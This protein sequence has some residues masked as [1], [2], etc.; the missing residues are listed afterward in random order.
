MGAG[1]IWRIVFTLLIFSIGVA[2]AQSDP[3]D[4]HILANGHVRFDSGPEIDLSQLKLRL[5]ELS[6]RGPRPEIRLFPDKGASYSAVAPVLRQFQE[7]GF[8]IGIITG[9]EL[10]PETPSPPPPVP[11]GDPTPRKSP[12]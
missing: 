12:Q 2:Y 4:L 3:R 7:L 8:R 6:Q 5:E 9:R 1:M 11:P 10:P